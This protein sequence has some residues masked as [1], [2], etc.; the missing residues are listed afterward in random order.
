[1]RIAPLDV[2]STAS[3]DAFVADVHASAGA[4][5]VVVCNAGVFATG[6]VEEIDD[7]QALAI[8]D[9][10]T[11]GALRLIRGVLPIMRAQRDGVI[12]AVA[13]LSG[14]VPSPGS[15][16]YAA[17][18]LA[19]IGLL[20]ALVLEVEDFGIRVAC[21]EPGPY[22]TEMAAPPP[23]PAVGSP[24]DHLMGAVRA[25][26]ARR[27][28]ESGDPAEVARAAVAAALDPSAPLHVP[29]GRHAEQALAGSPERSS[30]WIDALRDELRA[31]IEARGSAAGD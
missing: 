3:V 29:V 23:P 17:S 20:E 30:A 10:N 14:R 7:E 24:Y 4:I 6:P 19:L 18:K 1:V 11:L 25:R 21:L 13:S 15:G 28:A 2:R 22:R 26:T 9:T 12:V 5:D 31:G 27:M 16:I 8:L